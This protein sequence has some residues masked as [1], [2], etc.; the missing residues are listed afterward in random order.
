MILSEE[1]KEDL[2]SFGKTSTI[3]SN[4]FCGFSSLIQLTKEHINVSSLHFQ[5]DTTILEEIEETDLQVGS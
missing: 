1:E 5:L 3:F 4:E 2:N